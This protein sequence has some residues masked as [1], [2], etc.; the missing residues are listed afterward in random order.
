M[1]H[2]IH[3]F[4]ANQYTFHFDVMELCTS[5]LDYI[6][7]SVTVCFVISLES[8]DGISSNFGTNF[9]IHEGINLFDFGG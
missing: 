4:Y 9:C 1:T 5:L 3:W 8:S 7:K 2:L 6:T